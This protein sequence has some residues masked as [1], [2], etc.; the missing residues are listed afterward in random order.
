MKRTAITS[1]LSLLVECSLDL[2]G[3]AVDVGSDDASRRAVLVQ[4]VDAADQ[5]ADNVSSLARRL[6]EI[7]AN[8][9]AAESTQSW[10]TGMEPRNDS[11]SCVLGNASHTCAHLFCSM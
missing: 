9:A 4:T 5:R 3:L 7:L 8:Q 10:V 6:L 2:E 11:L 1:A